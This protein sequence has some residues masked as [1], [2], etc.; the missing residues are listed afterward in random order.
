MK[1]TAYLLIIVPCLWIG[2][3]AI[4]NSDI[5][6]GI[7]SETEFEVTYE[8]EL[9]GDKE[10]YRI[11]SF[12]P[13]NTIRQSI[14]LDSAQLNRQGID[15]TKEGE[16]QRIRW[17]GDLASDS[18]LSFSFKVSGKPVEYNLGQHL[19][20]NSTAVQR[21]Q[22]YLEPTDIVQSDHPKI[23]RKAEE[24]EPS[25]PESLEET[26]K[27]LYNFVNEIPNADISDLTDAVTCLQNRKC[28]CNGKS[29]LLAAL[30][31]A[32]D[33]PARIVGGLI[34]EDGSKRT[35]HSWVE[36]YIGDQWVPFDALNSYYGEL[37]S[38]YLEIYRGDEFLITRNTGYEFDYMYHIK[39]I[40]ANDYSL[41]SPLN[42]WML[43]DNNTLSRKPLLFLILLPLGAFFVALFKNVVGVDT[44]GVFLPVLIAFA[45]MEMGVIP[46]IL[47]FSAIVL[48]LGLL[49]FPLD[50]WGILHTPKMVAMLTIVAIYCLF[51]L[52]LF[53]A[54]GWVDP[55][56]TLMFPI[57]ILTMISERFA[58]KIEEES[59]IE[60]LFI[61]G[62][63]LLVTL[64]CYWVLS[65]HVIQHFFLT[66]P[67]ALLIIAG[68]SLFLGK[69]IGLRVT[70][71]FRF[72][73]INQE[74]DYVK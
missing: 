72:R 22:E 15:L 21:Y 46:G 2:F 51:S 17:T 74:V 14:R 54:T 9:Q 70:E 16:N 31:R 27:S 42:I 1:N 56:A 69:W 62:Q 38:H 47:F 8:F 28:S 35:S 68:L 65:A 73:K 53:N 67:E 34:L 26:A 3:R 25:D 30:F 49:S 71:H 52:Q 32:N 64:S 7:I 57:I 33:I 66:F 61:Y 55:S 59:I 10:D 18:T 60:A 6:S 40:R 37:P 39:K 29:R 63:T 4:V 41:F 20:N 12:L 50:E 24:L 45:F 48:C 58:Q 5:E 23:L 43:I 19:T 13:P 11:D 44:Y 36:A